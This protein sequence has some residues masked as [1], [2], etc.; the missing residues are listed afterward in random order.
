MMPCKT[1]SGIEEELM[2]MAK[3]QKKEIKGLETIEFQSAVFD[4]IP[5]EEQAKELLKSI[6]S[7]STYQKYFDTMMTVYKTQQLTEIEKLFKDTEF[8]ME[9]H[10]DLLLNDRN[11]NWVNQLKIIMKDETVFVAVGAGH[12]VGKEGLINLLREEGYTLKPILNK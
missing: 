12:L 3:Q 6:D 1:V 7:M 10:Q 8:G 4:S 2:K 11:K 5:Y 9:D